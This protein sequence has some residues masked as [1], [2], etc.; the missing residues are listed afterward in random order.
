MRK[1]IWILLLAL[2]SWT[3]ACT[4]QGGLFGQ[5]VKIGYPTFVAC[6]YP[7]IISIVAA[8]ERQVQEAGGTILRSEA[9]DIEVPNRAHANEALRR[10][11]AA[12]K[13]LGYI[14]L[15]SI[16]E[17]SGNTTSHMIL[18]KNPKTAKFILLNALVIQ[19]IQVTL[20]AVWSR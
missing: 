10:T 15:N 20:I 2:G 19:D 3:L 9:W 6:D 5:G 11:I 1:L 13:G 16:T 17:D 7:D 14:P 18:L 4:N 8:L 12:L